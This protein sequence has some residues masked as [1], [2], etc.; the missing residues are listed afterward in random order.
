[1]ISILHPSRSRPDKSLST[2]KKWLDLASKDVEVI[3]SLDEDDPTK[4]EYISKYLSAPVPSIKIVN[5]NKSAV[6]AINNAAKIATGDI[7]IVVSD[8]TECF[9]KWDKTILEFAEGRTDWIMKFQDGT[10]PWLV[11]MPVM[12]RVYYDRF[13]YIYHPSYRHMYCD[14]EL[15]TVADM[16][17]RKIVSSAMFYHNYHSICSAEVQVD[18][19]KL[20]N[21]ATF[22]EGRKNY[23]ARKAINFDLIGDYKMP[24]N[25][26]TRM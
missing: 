18:Q 17:G 13:G 23:I 4:D 26:Y 19:L 2:I 16:L 15:T 7:M 25:I 21:D 9:E 3:L 5:A 12:D 10:Q 6:D 22:E 14:T 20:R 11:T 24:D 8:D 1:M